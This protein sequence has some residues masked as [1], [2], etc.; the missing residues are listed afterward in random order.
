MIHKSS[1]G[2]SSERLPLVV[3]TY[4]KQH[5]LNLLTGILTNPGISIFG[6]SLQF[7]V[8]RAGVTIGPPL[9][10]PGTSI[11]FSLEVTGISQ[12]FGVLNIFG[13]VNRFGLKT[14]TGGT[15]KNGF[16]FKNAFNLKNAIDIGN[17]VTTR[18]G[19]FIANGGIVTPKIT[20]AFGAFASVAA[21]LRSLIFHIQANQGRDLYILA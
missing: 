1:L 10:I 18:N 13:T 17:S 15:I 9:S 11:P 3:Q 8:V 6:G 21:P 16:S 7:G 4:Q 20:A 5:Y 12:Y 19:K 2:L 14:A